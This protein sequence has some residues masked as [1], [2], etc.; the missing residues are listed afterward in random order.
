[1]LLVDKK[2]QLLSDQTT[3]TL[4]IL[5][6]IFLKLPPDDITVGQILFS[7][8]IW[9]SVIVFGVVTYVFSR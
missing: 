4:Q 7:C 2:L 8:C 3:D 1:M 5:R 9:F 6:A